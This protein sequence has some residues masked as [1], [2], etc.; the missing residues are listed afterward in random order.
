MGS[1]ASEDSSPHLRVAATTPA[2]SGHTADQISLGD[3]PSTTP[4]G[5]ETA[6]ST[7]PAANTELDLS[8]DWL[9]WQLFNSQVPTGWLT[10]G[11]NPLDV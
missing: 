10:S 3:F 5:Y 9:M 8:A 6:E 11:V 1:L 4:F 7:E 2:T